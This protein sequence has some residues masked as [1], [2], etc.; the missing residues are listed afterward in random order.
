MLLR[1][2]VIQ[3][4]IR[5]S[6][7]ILM[8]KILITIFIVFTQFISFAWSQEQEILVQHKLV[9]QTQDMKLVLKKTEAD[10]KAFAENFTVHLDKNSKVVSPQRVSGSTLEPV[11]NVSIKKCVFIFCQTI[12]L[13]VAF[14]LTV[15]DGQPAAHC[16]R[17]YLLVVD[18][19]RSSSMLSDLYQS[20]NTLIC[21]NKTAAG[22]ETSLQIALMHAENYSSG[23][24]QKNAFDLISLQPAAILESFIKVM[25]LNGVTQIQLIQ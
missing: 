4:Q 5:L 8:G 21:I 12:D 13:D 20:M 15:L 23:I 9:M 25:K 7:G 10:I 22:Y 2:N 6:R 11:L 14:K 24:V 17:N 16:A 3:L 1:E 19:Q 18:F